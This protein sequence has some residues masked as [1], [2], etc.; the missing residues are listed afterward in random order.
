MI[1]KHAAL[2]TV[3]DKNGV[4]IVDMD[5]HLA[6]WLRRC[7]AFDIARSDGIEHLDHP[8]ASRLRQM[9][10]VGGSLVR[11]AQTDHLVASPK[12]AV[13]EQKVR[14]AHRF[15]HL[16]ADNT[17]PW[18]VEHALTGMPVCNHEADVVA[19]HWCLAMRRVRRCLTGEGE[20]R[21]LHARQ[22]GNVK[23]FAVERNASTFYA[24]VMRQDRCDR[25]AASQV[26]PYRVGGVQWQRCAVLTQHQQPC[27]VVYLRVHHED[28]GDAAVP[29]ASRRLHVGVRSDLREQVR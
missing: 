14:V 13:H 2:G 25:E 16:R 26:V 11:K 9:A 21:N 29:G 17:K 5:E 20:R 10:H 15:E 6:Y 7:N 22:T 4:R 8:T 23:R 24:A 1:D 28:R 3:L 27:N 12:R 18:C 19:T